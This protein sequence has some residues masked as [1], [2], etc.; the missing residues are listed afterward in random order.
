MNYEIHDNSHPYFLR[1]QIT[2]EGSQLTITGGKGEGDLF[3]VE[4]GIRVSVVHEDGYVSTKPA[5]DYLDLKLT[6]LM[7]DDD[8]VKASSAI[9][10]ESADS[11]TSLTISEDTPGD[12]LLDLS[13]F[14]ID[15]GSAKI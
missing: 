15:V 13:N 9:I 5:D 1:D 3:T 6:L 7:T 12:V 11:E 8:Y 10:T 2:L 4:V 14:N